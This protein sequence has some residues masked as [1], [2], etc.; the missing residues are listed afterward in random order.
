[1]I[2]GVEF[3]FSAKYAMRTKNSFFLIIGVWCVYCEVWIKAEERIELQVYN[4]KFK[5]QMEAF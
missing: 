4:T 5:N 2:I 3:V 1:M